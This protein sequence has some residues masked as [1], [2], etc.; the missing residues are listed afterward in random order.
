[1]EAGAS[2]ATEEHSLVD[3]SLGLD[4]LAEASTERA[5]LEV[6]HAIRT[7]LGMEVAFISEFEDERRIFRFVDEEEGA[8]HLE[9]GASDPVEESY[10]QRVVDG[11]LPEVIHDARQEPAALDLAATREMPIGAH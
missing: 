2:K 5:L 4:E 10:C 7:H 8:P 9:V 1:M 6:L 3:I 11:R